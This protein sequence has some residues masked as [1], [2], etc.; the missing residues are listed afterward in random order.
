VQDRSDAPGQFDSYGVFTPSAFYSKNENLWY[1]FFGGVA[2]GSSAH[3]EAIGVA[4]AHSPFG[5]W[6]KSPLNPV[7]DKCAFSLFSFFFCFV[8]STQAFFIV[9]CAVWS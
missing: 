7:I 4:T 3:V 5:P 1:L 8:F 9:S 6:T 2:T